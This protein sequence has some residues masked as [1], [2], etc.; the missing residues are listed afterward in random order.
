MDLCDVMLYYTFAEICVYSY[1]K[2]DIKLPIMSSSYQLFFSVCAMFIVKH[3]IFSFYRHL[4]WLS[5]RLPK[6]SFIVREEEK[7]NS[8]NLNFNQLLSPNWFQSAKP[9]NVFF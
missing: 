6:S 4:R 3:V 5:F 9:K 7:Q 8:K 2:A 1:I